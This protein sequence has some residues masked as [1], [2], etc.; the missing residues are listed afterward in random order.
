LD[1][2]LGPFVK[3]LPTSAVLGAP[4]TI[5][6]TNL[7]GATSVSF[8][9][10]PAVVT[11]VSSSGITTTVPAGATSGKVRVVT[12][13]GTLLSNMRFGVLPSISMFLPDIGP[14]GTSGVVTGESFTGATSVAFGG[15]GATSFT[16][17][18]ST[19]IT[20]TVPSTAKTGPSR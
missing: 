8:N 6:G 9:G 5:L 18:S 14:V 3:T 16:V 13:G 19:K 17:D 15:W 10:T 2:G 7:G 11:L 4:V 20:A 12:P 1:V